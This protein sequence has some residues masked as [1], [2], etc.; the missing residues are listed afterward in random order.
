MAFS[1]TIHESF[2]NARLAFNDNISKPRMM[3][4]L[5]EHDKT[6]R[7][8]DDYNGNVQ[9]AFTVLLCTKIYAIAKKLQVKSLVK[10]TEEFTKQCNKYGRMYNPNVQKWDFKLVQFEVL[11][12][13]KI[14]V[15]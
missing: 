12:Q 3:A 9:A 8:L 4:T 6:G 10:I 15:A 7:L 2:F 1:I 14:E 11:P 13:F 5:A